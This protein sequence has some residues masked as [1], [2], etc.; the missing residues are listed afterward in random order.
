MRRN[1]DDNP[2]KDRIVSVLDAETRGLIEVAAGVYDASEAELATRI[3]RAHAAGTS[4]SWLEELMLM[5]VLFI[6]FPRA[7]VVAKALR[8]ILPYPGDAG[9]A[10]D[11]ARWAEW[12]K[13]GEATCRSIY[14]ANYDA[15]RRNVTALHPALDAWIEIDGYGRTLS[16]PGLDLRRRELC[17]LA[18]LVPQDVP[19]QL[20]S[21]LH[22]A[23]NAGAQPQE[24]DETLTVIEAAHG[25]PTAR[26]A[27]ARAMWAGL[28]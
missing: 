21:H 1:D 16:R 24:V 27:A 18:M 10:A 8:V 15:L 13:R 14:G 17:V 28:R 19:R 2:A 22:G 12:K 6:G 11:Y 4:P 20:K 25:A 3:T 23:L 26:L 7:L 5:A 9:D